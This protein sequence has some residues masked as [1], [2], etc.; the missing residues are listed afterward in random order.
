LL[1]Y[2]P[3]SHGRGHLV[4]GLNISPVRRHAAS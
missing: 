3:A 2:P 4:V 1:L